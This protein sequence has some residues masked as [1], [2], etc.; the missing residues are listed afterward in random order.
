MASIFGGF[1]GP[2]QWMGRPRLGATG[3][4]QSV[5]PM[6]SGLFG[7]FPGV[8]P[9]MGPGQSGAAGL[10]ELQ[11]RMRK[12]AAEGTCQVTYGPPA[13]WLGGRGRPRGPRVI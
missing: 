11:E 1:G 3:A 10:L 4:V 9:G 5:S 2:G 7:G 6:G 8:F 12:C 13:L